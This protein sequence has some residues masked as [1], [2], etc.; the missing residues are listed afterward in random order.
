MS[1][2]YNILQDICSPKSC[3]N[4]QGG[5]PVCGSNGLSYPNRCMLELARCRNLNLTF[6]HRG[7]CKTKITCSEY[8][9]I[10]SQQKFKPQCRPNG[11]FINSQCYPDIGY[12][13]CVTKRGVP[14]SFSVTKHTGNKLKCKKRKTIRRSPQKNQMKNCKQH[15]KSIF[16]SNLIGIFHTEW[17]RDNPN[18]YPGTDPDRVVLEWKFKKLDVDQNGKLDKN[19]FRDLRRIVK[20]VVKP[21][22]CARNFA[23]SCDVNKDQFIANLEWI[24]C[25]KRDGMD[26]R[27][28]R[29]SNIK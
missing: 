28:N 23:K 15:D 26:G 1:N 4:Y 10:H 3:R 7:P 9:R 27:Y 17:V 19:E 6:L 22:K 13:W 25:L 20:K 8:A 21:K 14:L 24:D 29:L 16:N 5:K 2:V 12:C 11:F 18:S